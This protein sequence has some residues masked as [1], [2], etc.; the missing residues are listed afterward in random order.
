MLPGETVTVKIPDRRKAPN[1]GHTD[2]TRQGRNDGTF[3]KT[4]K[5]MVGAGPSSDIGD[6]VL[7][8]QQGELGAGSG[9]ITNAARAAALGNRD[10]LDLGRPIWLAR[11]S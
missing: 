11:K 2:E 7:P 8:V 3:T 4:A 5:T 9:Q 10:L 6:V 1:V